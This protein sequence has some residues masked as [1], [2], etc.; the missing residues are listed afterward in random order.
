MEDI[1]YRECFWCDRIFYLI[2]QYDLV[3]AVIYERYR[4]RRNKEKIAHA[5]IPRRLN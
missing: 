4:S 5:I 3:L 2:Q 1:I